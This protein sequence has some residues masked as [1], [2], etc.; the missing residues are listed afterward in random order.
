MKVVVDTGVLVEVLEGS[1]LGSSTW[2]I[3]ENWS[4]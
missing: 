4:P 2:L 1:E 3:A